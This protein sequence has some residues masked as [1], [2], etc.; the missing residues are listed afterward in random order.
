[1]TTTNKVHGTDDASIAR[2]IR[3]GVAGSN[4]PGFPNFEEEDLSALVKFVQRFAEG[5]AAAGMK[6]PPGDAAK[7]QE[8]Y[9]RQRCE[10]C[11]RIG[12]EGSVYGPDL[13]RIGASRSY[14]YILESIVKP[15]ADVPREQQGVVVTLANGSK[16]TGVRINEDSFSVQLRD[17][18]Q[19]YRSFLKTEV[20]SVED[21]PKSLMPAYDK[22]AKADL[23]NLIA[24]LLTLK[25]DNTSGKTAG[26]AKGIH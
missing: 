9:A 2:I 14:E 10:S 7:G 17:L 6:A 26:T 4:M 1:M 24:Y 8:V 3:E 11:H 23:D 15:D 21:A 18:S 13:T 16:V 5:S 12:R 19:R 20:K 22:L 25:G